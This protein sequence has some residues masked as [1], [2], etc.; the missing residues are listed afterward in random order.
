MGAL[1]DGS[2]LAWG[3][4]RFGQCGVDPTSARIC[5][6][7]RVPVPDHVGRVVRVAAGWSHSLALTG[8]RITSFRIII[9]SSLV[10]DESCIRLYKHIIEF[11]SRFLSDTGAIVSWGRADYGQLGR[12]FADTAE[13]DS[14]AGDLAATAASSSF[15]AR[16]HSGQRYDQRPARVPTLPRCVHVASGSE[17]SLALTGGQLF[18]YIFKRL[19]T[20]NPNYCSCMCVCVARAESGQ[21][22]AWGWNEHGNVGVGESVEWVREPRRVRLPGPNPEPSN[23]QSSSSS[24]RDGWDESS[25]SDQHESA[26]AAAQQGLSH[27]VRAVAA[28]AAHTF[29][30]ASLPESVE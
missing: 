11:D 22:W 27:T 7:T 4:N 26:D 30:I 18:N 1:A 16:A 29:V 14:D 21:L 15:G 24:S 3:S 20:F 6:P 2:L 12:P 19:V 8:S 23:C 10:G 9:F 28:G 13:A 17:H 25:S 5:A